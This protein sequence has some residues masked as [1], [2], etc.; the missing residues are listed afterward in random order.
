MK[1]EWDTAKSHTNRLKHGI[2]FETAKD[3]WLD[4]DRI[5]I[6]APHPVEN[7]SIVIGKLHKKLWTAV[8]TLRG[9]T[10]RIISVRHSRQKEA[11]LYEK[12]KTR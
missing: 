6:N 7:R 12:E 3:I 8:Y 11:E 4:D 5:E 9:E 2:D 10:I 1:F